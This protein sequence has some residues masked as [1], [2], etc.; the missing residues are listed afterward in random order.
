M[1]PGK[2]CPIVLRNASAH[3]E[4]LAFRHPLA[5]LQLVKGSIEPGESPAHA[6]LRELCEESGLVATHVSRDLGPWASGFD[7]QVWSF[8]RCEVSDPLAD[9]WSHRTLDG[10]GLVFEF[11][12][13]PLHAEPDAA[14][15]EVYRRA[16]AAVRHRLAA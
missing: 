7:G 2:A 12:W 4:L 11:F 3:T 9:R 16:I 15:H 8:Q 6:A 13:H 5:G 14:W 10:G 1:T